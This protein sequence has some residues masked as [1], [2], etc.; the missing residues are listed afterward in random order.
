MCL[1]LPMTVVD[2]D[3]F[4]ALCEWHGETRR[5]STLLVG[6]QAPGARLLIHLDSAIRVLDDAEAETIGRALDGL[7][8]AAEGRPFEHLFADLMD[9]EP[10]LP[11]HLRK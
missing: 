6:R 4:S 3:D 7:A 11:A 2:G 10:E 9:R 5:V 1:G 8:A